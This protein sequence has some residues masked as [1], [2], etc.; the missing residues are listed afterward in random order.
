MQD[1]L[2]MIKKLDVRVPAEFVQ[3]IVDIAHG[4]LTPYTRLMKNI[5]GL[6]Y[7]TPVFEHIKLTLDDPILQSYEKVSII[8]PHDII[9]LT[10]PS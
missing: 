10:Q 1:G 4:F 7:K 8:P 3:E 6:G 9:D 5:N 2:D